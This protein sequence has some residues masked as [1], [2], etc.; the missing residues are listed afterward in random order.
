YFARKITGEKPSLKD[1]IR[2]YNESF[3]NVGFIT[4]EAED[5]RHQA[6]ITALTRFFKE[7]QN[8]PLHPLN[9]EARFEFSEG[10]ICVRGRYDLILKSAEDDEIVDFK[11]SNVVLQKDADR[12]IKQSS[13][14]KVYALSW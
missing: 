1:L 8:N 2:D 3:K 14:M 5:K 11:T 12:R 7:D 4:R 9:V 6:G 13:Q 10:D